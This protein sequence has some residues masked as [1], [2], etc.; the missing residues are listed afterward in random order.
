MPTEISLVAE[1]ELGDRRKGDKSKLK[2][3]AVMFDFQ[4]LL[5]ANAALRLL[6]FKSKNI[7]ELEALNTYFDRSISNYKLLEKG[8]IFLFACFVHN[9]KDF[10][11]TE[12]Y[13]I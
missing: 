13:K 11:Y 1:S 5:V 4:K 6:I 7:A 12:K 3:P 9:T 2:N 10:Y 8:S